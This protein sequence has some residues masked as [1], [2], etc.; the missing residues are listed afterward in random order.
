MGQDMAPDWA[1]LGR[2]GGYRIEIDAYPPFHGEF[3]MGLPGG[4][5]TSFDDALVTT[6]SR[7]VNAIASVVDA[8]PGYRTLNELAPIGGRF[9]FAA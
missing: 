3:P 2:D 8:C 7:C 4:A 9:S 5:G 6:A 1:R